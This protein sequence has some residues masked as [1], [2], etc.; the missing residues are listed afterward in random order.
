MRI[1][2]F[3]GSFD[4]VHTGHATLANE[5][6]QCGMFDQVWMVPARVSPFKTGNVRHATAADRVAMCRLVAE[7][8]AAVRV[9]DIEMSLPEPSYTYRTL[10]EL[11]RRYPEHMF[12]IIIGSDNLSDF[13]RWYNAE[14]IIREFGVTVY[15]RPG[16]PVPDELPENVAVVGDMPQVMVSSTH[17]RMSI[18]EDRNVNFLVPDAVLQYIKEK[19]LY[20]GDG[21]D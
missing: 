21:T 17:I 8:C 10:C 1:G 4:P 19:K 11:R 6:S 20:I 7:R 5:L 13:Y 15:P 14:G 2:I 16:Y 18:A 9:D 3:G 12:R